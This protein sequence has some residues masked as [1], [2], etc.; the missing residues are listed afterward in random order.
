MNQFSGD[1]F[2]PDSRREEEIAAVAAFS[3]SNAEDG[4]NCPA[5]REA[6][7][8]LISASLLRNVA[9]ATISFGTP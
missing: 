6:E 1:N 2:E 5:Q 4:Q 9:I 7:K 3:T 8:W